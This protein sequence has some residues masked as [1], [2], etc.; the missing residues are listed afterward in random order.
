MA[1][2]RLWWDE[3][4]VYLLTLI[5]SGY[6][7][8]MARFIAQISEL[9]RDFK[10]VFPQSWK[11]MK[12]LWKEVLCHLIL[13]SGFKWSTIIHLVVVNKCSFYAI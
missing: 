13:P 9:P 3:T 7:I 8:S 1:L 12:M 6:G 4:A 5:V 2:C 10:D 11:C